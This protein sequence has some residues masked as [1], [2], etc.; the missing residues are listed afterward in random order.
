MGRVSLTVNEK[1]CKVP[2]DIPG[3]IC[4]GKFILEKAVHWPSVGT[5]YMTLGEPSELL[6][7][8]VLAG[9]FKNLFV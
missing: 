2:S 7:R 3:F 9:K 8:I 6:V 4:A 5:I 1:R